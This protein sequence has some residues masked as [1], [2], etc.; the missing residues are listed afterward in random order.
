[1]P[2]KNYDRFYSSNK[3]YPQNYLFSSHF[4][5]IWHFTE[6]YES[7]VDFTEIPRQVAHV[8]IS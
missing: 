8:S 6:R 7:S 3:V 5:L 2:V 1:M 4:L